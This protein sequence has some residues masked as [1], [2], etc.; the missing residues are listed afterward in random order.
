MYASR[1]TPEFWLALVVVAG[2]AGCWHA[3]ARDRREAKQSGREVARLEAKIE[4]ARLAFGDE[5]RR[6]RLGYHPPENVV[7]FWRG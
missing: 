5:R 6:Q 4:K 3:V 1:M 2:A 7:D